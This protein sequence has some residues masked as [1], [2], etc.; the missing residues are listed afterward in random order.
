MGEAVHRLL[1]RNARKYANECGVLSLEYG[2]EWSWQELNN[3]ANGVA[4]ILLDAGLQRGERVAL[5]IPN[6]PEFLAAYFGV[7]KAGGVAV[8]VNVRLAKP[9]IEYIIDDSEAVKPGV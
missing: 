9:E 7:L 3:R 4:E 1:E 6:R 2:I 8:P 5:V